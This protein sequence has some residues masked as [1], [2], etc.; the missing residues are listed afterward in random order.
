M[1]REIPKQCTRKINGLIK[2]EFKMN[3]K[4]QRERRIKINITK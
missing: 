1:K 4:I 3:R 2:T